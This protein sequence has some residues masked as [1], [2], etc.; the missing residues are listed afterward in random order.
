MTLLDMVTEDEDKKICGSWDYNHQALRLL[1]TESKGNCF[2]VSVAIDLVLQGI[3]DPGNS[4]K[5]DHD[6]YLSMVQTVFTIR[7]RYD[8]VKAVRINDFFR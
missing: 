3:R 6:S 4:F 5:F 8:S 7:L 1:N 2:F